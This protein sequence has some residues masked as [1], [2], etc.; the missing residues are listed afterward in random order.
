MAGGKEKKWWEEATRIL[1]LSFPVK[2]LTSHVYRIQ[3]HRVLTTTPFFHTIDIG[4]KKVIT[5]SF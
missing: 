5:A 4:F 3:A 2:G 1:P